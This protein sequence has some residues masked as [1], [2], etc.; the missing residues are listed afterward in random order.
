M[1]SPDAEIKNAAQSGVLYFIRREK[2][3]RHFKDQIRQL[4]R[5]KAPLATVELIQPVNPILQGWGA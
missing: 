2:S 4:T 5:R 3:V 1:C